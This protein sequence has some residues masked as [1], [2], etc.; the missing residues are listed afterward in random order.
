MLIFTLEEPWDNAEAPLLQAG[1]GSWEA[2]P[3]AVAAGLGRCADVALQGVL[4][5][6]P[7]QQAAAV[8]HLRAP[9]LQDICERESSQEAAPPWLR[10]VKTLWR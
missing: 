3:G 4:T 7:P 8:G 9:V 6:T 10:R 1:E 2:A 5:S